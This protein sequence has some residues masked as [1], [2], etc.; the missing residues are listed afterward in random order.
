MS[1]TQDN[2]K[3]SAKIIQIN[4]LIESLTSDLSYVDKMPKD[5]ET[6]RIMRLVENLR[7]SIERY[8]DRSPWIWDDT[9]SKIRKDC[10]VIDAVTTYQI[11]YSNRGASDS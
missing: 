11:Y 10:D 5:G 7:R 2:R 8:D 1:E 6:D 9:E 4:N 3:F